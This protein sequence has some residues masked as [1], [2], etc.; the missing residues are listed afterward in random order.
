MKVKQFLFSILLVLFFSTSA[1]AYNKVELGPGYFPQKTR[2]RPISNAYIY[3]GLPD[4]N[5]EIVGN[6]KTLYVQQEDGAIVA[7]AQPI[8]TSAGGVPLYSEA[9]VT[10]LVDGDYSLK[11]LSSTE[12][13]VYYIPNQSWDIALKPGNYYYPEYSAIDQGITGDSNTLK[14]YVDL[15]ATDFATIYLRHSSGLATTTYTLTTDETISSNITLKIEDGA[16]LDGA[17][18]LTI[19]GPFEHSLSQCF[20]S[21]ITIAFGSRVV[22]EVYPEWWEENTIP[23]TTD[24]T[25]AIQA[26]LDAF[27]KVVFQNT[28][29]S[30]NYISVNTHNQLIGKGW[31]TIIDS[32]STG[33]GFVDG[34]FILNYLNSAT[35][36]KN[37][38]IKDLQMTSAAGVFWLSICIGG[39]AENV[40]I[41]NVSF[42]GWG[43]GDA[44]TISGQ[45][46]APVPA[47][48]V[49]KNVT[50]TNSEFIGDNTGRQAISIIS[51]DGVLI[52]NNYFYQ[53][54]GNNPATIDIEPDIPAEYARNITISNNGFENIGTAIDRKPPLRIDF[55]NMNATYPERRNR[56]TFVDN[57]VLNAS[58][59]LAV[60]TATS[61]QEPQNITIA[62]NVFDTVTGT[63][64]FSSANGLTIENNVFMDCGGLILGEATKLTYGVKVLDNIFHTS[65]DPGAMI[66]LAYVDDVEI[67]GNSFIDCGVDVGVGIGVNVLYLSTSTVSNLRIHD[68]D[69][70]TPNAI[71]ERV[72]FNNG[73][74]QDGNSHLY[75][76]IIEDGIALQIGWSG[77]YGGNEWGLLSITTVSFAANADTALYTV[78]TGKRCVLSHAK[79]IAGAD[80]GATTTISIGANGAET[81]FIPANTLSNLDAQYDS[82]IVKPIP[83]TTPLK[84]K[85]YAAT[86]VIDARVANQSGGATNTVYLFGILY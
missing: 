42:D 2:G 55:G 37:V 19:N 66:S 82:V 29:Y 41:D 18:T 26:A 7:V 83:N 46:Y 9:P 80:A 84:S 49:A 10:L 30:V 58:G 23:G 4:T 59:I 8:R 3:V 6:Q 24:M 15:V 61:G 72:F 52:D 51:A 48:H 57:Y 36:V 63:W 77:G 1:F 17:G 74:T 40:I 34:T 12:S 43:I 78:P 76:N 25:A 81:D 64:G 54:T 53:T 13:Q 32:T 47:D 60:G 31:S 27:S 45:M 5:P 56:I 85:S 35:P 38:V 21:S 16:I 20:G 14:Y 79:I 69:F 68:N 65:G 33:G 73:A 67:A 71:S 62:R 39:Y 86:T 75:N 70:S 22:N 44:I 28:T 11:I 50:V